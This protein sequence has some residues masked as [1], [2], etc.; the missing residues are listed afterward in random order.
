MKKRLFI[1]TLLLAVLVITPVSAKEVNSFYT[2]ANDTVKMENTIIGDSAIAGQLVDI[3]GNIDGIGFIAGKDVNVNGSIEYGFVAGENVNIKN[4]TEK[5][6]FV[7]GKSIIFDKN[8]NIGRDAFVVGSNIT[9]DGKLNRDVSAAGDNIV[10][11]EGSIINGT[12]ALKAE[13]IT[14][15]KDV[16]I[17]GTLKHNKDSEI[18]I[19]KSA[20]INKIEKTGAIQDE[21]NTNVSEI[22]YSLVNLLIVFLVIALLLPKTISKTEEVYND[23]KSKGYVKNFGIGVVLLIVTPI[24]AFLLISNIGVSLGLILIALY[25]IAIYLSYIYSGYILGNLL[26][27]KWLKL[28]SNKYLV[29]LIGITI[30]KLLTYVPVIG[31]LIVVIA[32]SIGLATILEITKSKEVP[33]KDDKVKEAKITTKKVKR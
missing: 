14:I 18:K 11:K 27:N 29:G 12:I 30:L 32:I 19:D 4:K 21:D 17:K 24:T 28:K 31:G 16:V 9:F 3:V 23:K 5:S 26:I 33:V 20:N 25:V 1:I 22:I 15:E 2:E 7:A 8:A 6:L 13:K 10:I